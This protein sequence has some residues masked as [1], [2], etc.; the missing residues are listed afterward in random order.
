MLR[1]LVATGQPAML[2][3]VAHAEAPHSHM[4]TNTALSTMVDIEAEFAECQLLF[5][6]SDGYPRMEMASRR[7]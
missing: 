7:W 5:S 6:L 3:R 1:G 2:A 4:L